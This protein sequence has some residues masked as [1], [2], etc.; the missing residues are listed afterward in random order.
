VQEPRAGKTS[1]DR[2][3][4]SLCSIQA[5]SDSR[6]QNRR[7][8]CNDTHTRGVRTLFRRRCH[9][10]AQE[11]EPRPKTYSSYP[12]NLALSGDGHLPWGGEREETCSQ[13]CHR[14]QRH[15]L[16]RPIVKPRSRIVTF[17]SWEPHSHY[18]RRSSASWASLHTGFNR[19]CLQPFSTT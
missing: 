10:A 16:L 4:A 8:V 7:E 9:L 15:G 13:C 2:A 1:C 17:P 19:V 11:K 18:P 3:L 5:K 6:E 14:S 12:D